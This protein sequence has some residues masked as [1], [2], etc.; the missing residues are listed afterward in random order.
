MST[1]LVTLLV[2]ETLHV[3]RRFLFCLLTVAAFGQSFHYP[4]Q[5]PRDLPPAAQ[6]VAK[7]WFDALRADDWKTVAR[8]GAPY[9]SVAYS[10]KDGGTDIRFFKGFTHYAAFLVA[11]K[12]GGKALD[13]ILSAYREVPDQGEICYQAGRLLLENDRPAEAIRPLEDAVRL[14]PFPSARVDLAIALNGAGRSSEALPRL[15]Q[16]DR[17]F[18][19]NRRIRFDLAWALT[20]LHRQGEAAVVLQGLVAK[21]P[22]DA[23][24]HQ[25]LGF[26]LIDLGK[27]VEAIVHLK[28]SASLQPKDYHP[29]S[30]MVT[31]FLALNQVSEARM[32]ME[33]ARTLGAPESLV[34]ALKREIQDRE[35]R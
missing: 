16:L 19:D 12:S 8:L 17:E 21:D 28:A 34:T 27:P 10:A 18:P 1:C 35:P 15:Q 24:A 14:Y 13:H 29:W 2:M 20:S 30:E 26:V 31:A 33:K 7:A 5:P 4:A 25:E 9:T 3:I 11:P 22:K 23:H 32:A 6:K